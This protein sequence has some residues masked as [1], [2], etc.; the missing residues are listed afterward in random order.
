MNSLR[1]RLIQKK[2]REFLLPTLLITTANNL[3]SFVDMLLIS[4]FLGAN[5][6]PAV[7]LC[8]PVVAF[9]SV[10]HGMIGIGGSLVAA[11]AQADHDENE[12]NR[13]FSI[14][15]STVLGIGI[16]ITFIGTVMK[17][18]IV[19]MLCGDMAIQNDVA[20]YYSV[21]VLGFPLMC[22]LTSLSFFVKTDGC[23]RI[24]SD[25]IVISN[26]VNLCMDCILMKGFGAGLEGAAAATITGYICGIIFLLI[27]YGRYSRRQFRFV[28]PFSI[29]AA[30][31]F[32]RLNGICKKGFSTASVWFYLMI[33]IQVLNRLTLTYGG[34]TGIEVYSL[35][36]N[37][38][39]VC[40][41][42]FIGIS[43]TMSPIVGAYAHEGDYDRVRFILKRSIKLVLAAAL[44]L[45]AVFAAFPGIIL[46]LY[47]VAQTRSAVYFDNIRIFTLLYPG[48]GFTFLMNYY[49]QAIGKIKLSERL[50]ILEG[51]LLPIGLAC[52]LTPLLHM[53]G[54]W[55]A[56]ILSENI[57][58]VSIIVILFINR[59]GNHAAGAESFLLPLNHE[60][61]RYEF[62]VKTDTT[63][64]VRM[65]EKAS[66]YIEGRTDRKTALI[67][68]MALE[69]MLTGIV[70]ANQD[71]GEVIDVVIEDM[72]N[73]I[74]ISIKHMGVGFNPLIYDENLDYSFD[75]AAVLKKI[76]SKIEY[77]LLLG[78]NSTL[79]QVN[80][81]SVPGH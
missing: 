16:L 25:S 38:L 18:G 26:L 2:Y 7:Q 29:D 74:A 19:S 3:T 8:F 71:N 45:A 81:T 11:S 63:E 48:L 43:Q 5:R 73:Q 61:S 24:A 70:L 68:C 12:G 39:S 30:S 28:N 27:N 59:Y 80:K 14:S 67:T 23:A 69:E 10:F 72:E 49:F 21:L 50:T 9:V 37:S 58:A 51:L 44:I 6:M 17:P 75:N 36:R 41:I 62:S 22:F 13:I 4:A 66:E 78:I 77:D 60:A 20:S 33:T 31:F 46:F 35:C 42:F 65:S 54:I 34:K 79:I 1:Y 15:M 56:M 53:T 55:I 32:R 76:S 47:G 52:I 64:A 57:S 40:Y